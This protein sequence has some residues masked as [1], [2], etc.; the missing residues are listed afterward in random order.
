VIRLPHLFVLQYLK[1]QLE[2]VRDHP[3]ELECLLDPYRDP[4]ICE[5]YGEEFIAKAIQ[6]IQ[7]NEIN[8]VLGSRLDM[9]KL[10]NIAVTY[11]GGVER[12]Q[13]IGQDAGSQK[14]KITPTR[15][16]SFSVKDVEDGDLIVSSTENITDKVWVGLIAKNGKFCSRIQEILPEGSDV[17]L[18]L[19]TKADLAKVTL[20]DWFADSFVKH[21]TRVIGSSLDS[22]NIRVYLTVQGDPELCEMLST[23][24]R[25]IL[26]QSRLV[27]E[28]NGLYEVDFSHSALSRSMDYDESQAWVVQ[29]TISG[30][31]QDSW[32]MNKFVPADRVEIVSLKA[33]RTEESGDEVEWLAPE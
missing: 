18:V 26:K 20:Q 2:Y 12:T 13:F 17:R 15:Y 6:W 27:L 7:Q 3:E 14:V 8:Y 31:L 33:D 29:F 21:E 16:A 5:V 22:V 32:I 9:D 28:S 10:P 30:E 24:V 23:V 11:E 25:Y 4:L 19:E 1:K